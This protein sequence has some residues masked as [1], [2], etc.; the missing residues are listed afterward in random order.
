MLVA[1]LNLLT[2]WCICAHSFSFSFRFPYEPIAALHFSLGLT[3]QS[4]PPEEL[5]LVL[6]P[7]FESALAL[8]LQALGCL[9]LAQT[10]REPVRPLR[11]LPLILSIL[12]QLLSLLLATRPSLLFIHHML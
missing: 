6:L 3:P 4:V 10:L 2:R 7:L 9:W 8:T 5:L 11:S 1:W 12:P